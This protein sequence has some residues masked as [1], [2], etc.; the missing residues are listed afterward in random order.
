MIDYIIDGQNRRI[1]KKVNGFVTN[2][3]LYQDQLNPIA[4]LDSS[5]NVLARYVYG[6][7]INVPDY[8][9]KGDTTLAVITDHLGS[10]RML[11][12]TT[13]GEVVQRYDYDEFG[14]TVLTLGSNF[15]ALN[16]AGGLY[17]EHT[18][19]VRFGAR[20]FDPVTARWN[21]KDPLLFGAGQANL[22]MYCGNDPVN[23][24]DPS[25]LKD[26]MCI[27]AGEDFWEWLQKALGIGGDPAGNDPTFN[28]RPYAGVDE[29]V[30]RFQY[31]A[32]Q[33]YIILNANGSLTATA[34]V[35]T[36][37]G[38]FASGLTSSILLATGSAAITY[39]Q[40]SFN[41]QITGAN[42]YTSTA[43]GVG[44]SI[45][46]AMPSPYAQG[47]AGA[48]AIIVTLAPG[49]ANSMYNQMPMGGFGPFMP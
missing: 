32:F 20:D 7:K 37:A 46:G 25:G 18:G 28:D 5:G 19:L 22:F 44:I 45:A 38:L 11:V 4:E 40:D 26:F 10:V 6:A 43:I 39:A 21:T 30:A 42:N 33:N 27:N 16:Y 48:S 35:P 13:N 2:R 23:R 3:W 36:T 12:N 41:S 34:L 17:D 49:V 47:I 31:D 14:N 9:I 8:V 15:L 1:A 24:L 29:N